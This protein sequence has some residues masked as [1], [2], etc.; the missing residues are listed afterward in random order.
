MS[1]IA[2]LGILV[3]DLIG[4][5]VDQLPPR[6][7]LG[8]V[9]QMTLHIGGCAANTGIDL[10]R[11]GVKTSVLGKVG[12]D[13]LGDFVARTLEAEGIDTRGVVR[14]RSVN[15][16]STMV[17]VDGEGERT[18]LHYLG[19]NAVFTEA[20]VDWSVLSESRTLHV[21][22]ALVMPGMDGEPMARILKR[23][24]EAGMVTSLDVVWDATG[25]WMKTLG[26]CLEHLDFFMPSIS[27]AQAITG[28]ENTEQVA[29]ALRD[30]G[31][32]TVALKLGEEGCYVSGPD[33]AFSA[34]C[35]RVRAVDGTGSG[36][37]FDAGLLCGILRGWDLEKSARF[38]CAV[39]ALCVT[40]V[41]ATA[42][43]KSMEQAEDFLQS[44][45]G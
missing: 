8:L 3:A 31:V 22:G 29:A 43:V 21:A 14:D 36:D 42:G 40:D 7:R 35:F 33:G 6:G 27:E 16:S 45:G 12:R 2:C 39:G 28:R 17:L 15:T 24:R 41:G 20:D 44:H 11:L 5:P 9:D 19:G 32:R 25:K 10:A 30:A 4:R 34:P 23:A 1:E 37:A 38:G 26:P 13:G 18:F